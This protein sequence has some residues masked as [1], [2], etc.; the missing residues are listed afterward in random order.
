M[1]N[2]TAPAP[3]PARH[4]HKKRK[5]TSLDVDAVRALVERRVRDS[6][7]SSSTTS[8]SM[9]LKGFE[10]A[11]KDA[12]CALLCAATSGA[13][14]SLNISGALDE[15]EASDIISA[16]VTSAW[17]VDELSLASRRE[18]F[19][20]V[21]EDDVLGFMRALVRARRINMSKCNVTCAAAAALARALMEENPLRRCESVNLRDNDVG[22]RGGRELRRACDAN[23]DIVE[24]IVT[25]NSVMASEDVEGIR[26]ACQKNRRA[27]LARAAL[28]QRAASG[29]LLEALSLRKMDLS[30]LDVPVILACID[31][32]CSV[33]RID[34]R[35]NAFTEMGLRALLD[36]LRI[37][38]G[39][40]R[41]VSINVSGNPGFG[42]VAARELVGYAAANY[43]RANPCTEALKS[44]SDR[45]LG[46]D[47][48]A[49]VAVALA[50]RSTSVTAFGVH[51]ND[52][53]PAGC[54]AIVNALMAKHSALRELAMYSNRMG[55]EGAK[56]VAS[57]VASSD[58][59]NVLDIGGNAIGD[60]GC[61]AISRAL[62][63]SSALHELHL[64]HNGITAFGGQALLAALED[65]RRR[66]VPPLRSIW[67]HGNNVDDVLTGR[68]MRMTSGA[69]AVM[70]GDVTLQRAM[71]SLPSP[72]SSEDI[73]RAERDADQVN[74]TQPAD[75][76][77]LANRIAAR[78]G[79]EYRARCS[80]HYK[81]TR[82]TAVVAGIVARDATLPA[83]HDLIVLSLGVGTKFIPPG[84]ATAIALQS[85]SDG[86][87]GVAINAWDAHVHDSHAEVLARRGLLRALYRE[88]DS[89]ARNG[90][91]TLL[92]P[93]SDNARLTLK[94]SVTLH[95]YVSTAPC[96]AASAGPKG[97]GV[98]E[99]MNGAGIA[100]AQHCHSPLV[101]DPRWFGACQKGTNDDDDREAPPGCVILTKGASSALSVPG[102]ALSCS[103][104][105]LRWNALGIQGAL[106]SHF[107]DPVRLT[108]V[109]IGRKYDYD[110]CRFATCCRVL[111][112]QN[113]HSA[114]THPAMLRSGVKLECNAADAASGSRQL[115]GDG[116][117]S[118]SWANGEGGASSHDGRTGTA[119]G[120]V[121]TTSLCSRVVLWHQFLGVVDAIR[122]GS[123]AAL[124][125]PEVDGAWTYPSLKR[126][127]KAY[128]RDRDALFSSL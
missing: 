100:A 40:E 86:M 12:L 61:D 47:G 13:V 70:D 96:G 84:V 23:G 103:D 27:S 98:Q 60:A 8:C 94:L 102:R 15:L 20:R 81:S 9:A 43:V 105:I 66:G 39:A 46:D 10:L 72:P 54:I 75:S 2:T 31:Q 1:S 117:E 89:Y 3:A 26:E 73:A 52:I 34:V 101:F 118:I 64:D 42:T 67:L 95:L 123:P 114:F 65:R 44:V 24:C 56:S 50:E 45:H 83:P 22:D 4:R 125:V 97:C 110:R 77:S 21:D 36:A 19:A 49:L 62:R 37:H 55:A 78:V 29:N 5:N 30:D 127:S 106:L 128:M 7:A 48:A 57:L 109:V 6:Q 14:R 74:I 71:E 82:G 126:A 32:D 59:L 51:H 76:C 25:N 33:T 68:I 63:N 122:T 35:D 53:G 107:V 93:R 124:S 111:T 28:R 116:D 99:W 119:I 121:G 91:S 80:T 58:S 41:V 108:S 16:F 38:E 85:Q 17:E 92:E 79:A 120:G 88:I 113:V 87:D 18:L 104:K 11:T 115:A 69:I 112:T 90:S